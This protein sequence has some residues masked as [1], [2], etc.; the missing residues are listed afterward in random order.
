MFHPTNLIL[1]SSSSPSSNNPLP[2]TRR[3]ASLPSLSFFLHP[4]LQE[5]VFILTSISTIMS[6]LPTSILN[7][8][9]LSPTPTPTP[10]PQMTSMVKKLVMDQHRTMFYTV[11]MSPTQ[12]KK[13]DKTKTLTPSLKVG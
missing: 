3:R 5:G 10:S 1:R 12:Q 2:L 9:G 7:M 4:L 13:L 8:L 6:H 11:T